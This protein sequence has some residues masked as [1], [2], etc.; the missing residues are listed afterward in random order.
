[1]HL[2]ERVARRFT[3]ESLAGAGGMGAVYCATD[4]VTGARVAIKVLHGTTPAERARFENE[5]EALADLR[6]P[7]IVRYL[8]HG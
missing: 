6:H 2:G 3:I 5:A 1:M 7:A 4:A 8:A